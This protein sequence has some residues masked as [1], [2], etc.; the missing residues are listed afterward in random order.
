MDDYNSSSS[1][2]SSIRT[3][4]TS[5]SSAEA[6]LLLVSLLVEVP[7]VPDCFAIPFMARVLRK[8]KRT[9]GHQLHRQASPEAPKPKMFRYRG[10]SVL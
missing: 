4:S 8:C 3:S 2:S 10:T 9:A 1:S 7:I 5:S 6:L